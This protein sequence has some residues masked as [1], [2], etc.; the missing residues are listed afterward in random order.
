[1]ER[2]YKPPAKYIDLQNQLNQ[3]D[4]VDS[5]KITKVQDEIKASIGDRRDVHVVVVSYLIEA[6]SGVLLALAQTGTQL[7]AG[8]YI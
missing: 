8:Q 1:M 4:E 2:L 6:V 7:I 3:D 5:A